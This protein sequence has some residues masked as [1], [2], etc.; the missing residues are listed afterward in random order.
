MEQ[1]SPA[2]ER[3]QQAEPVAGLRAQREQ[4]S[5]PQICFGNAAWLARGPSAENSLHKAGAALM[6]RGR[7]CSILQ[8]SCR[9]S[10]QL[11]F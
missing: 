2:F 9:R 3:V 10:G 1:R 7:R 8:Q 11:R 4:V 6:L 5:G